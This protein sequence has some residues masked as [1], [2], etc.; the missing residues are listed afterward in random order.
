MIKLKE[1]DT[2]RYL[3]KY[4]GKY[5]VKA[6]LTLEEDFVYDIFGKLDDSYDDLYIPCYSNCEVRHTYDYDE[7]GV[8]FYI[9][10]KRPKGKIIVEELK[11]Q[12]KDVWFEVDDISPWDYLIYFYE[13]DLDKIFTIIKPYEGGAKISPYSPKN[14]PK[15]VSHNVSDKQLERYRNIISTLNIDDNMKIAQ[16][17]KKC[18]SDFCDVI[19]EIKGKDYDILKERKA[20]R[21]TLKEFIIYIGLYDKFL[22]FLEERIANESQG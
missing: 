2:F 14:L 1:I 10:C 18:T 4:V 20:L 3:L 6:H 9:Y 19:H 8:K 22:D 15:K 7:N 12:Y 13:K 5:R 17:I 11:K 16:F 21:M